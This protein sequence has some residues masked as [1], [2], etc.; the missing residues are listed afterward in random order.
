MKKEN[1]MKIQTKPKHENET[2]LRKRN[3]KNENKT[4]QKWKR[5]ETKL[6][7]KQ[8][9]NEKR[10][11]KSEKKNTPEKKTEKTYQVPSETHTNKH[12]DS[13][14]LIY[15]SILCSA[16]YPGPRECC[17]CLNTVSPAS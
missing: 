7:T 6:K 3:K 8:K 2:K 13:N 15:F 5:N 16:N 1:D 14:K 12:H 4:E 10:K 17:C 9:R 11:K